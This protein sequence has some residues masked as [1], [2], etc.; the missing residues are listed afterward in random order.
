MVG[1]GSL[2]LDMCPRNVNIEIFAKR[3]EE[4]EIPL[5]NV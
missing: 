3:K 4:P 1:V 5:H 2:R